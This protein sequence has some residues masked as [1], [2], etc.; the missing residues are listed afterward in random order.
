LKDEGKWVP[1]KK[2]A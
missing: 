2:E 1:K